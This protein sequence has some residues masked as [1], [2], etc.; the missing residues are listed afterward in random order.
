METPHTPL[1]WE[2]DG[3]SDI[4]FEEPMQTIFMVRGWGWLHKKYG[5]K[6]AIA[7]QRGNLKLVFKAVNNHD[8][9]VDLLSRAVGYVHD[10]VLSKQIEDLLNKIDNERK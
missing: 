1:P 4:Y 5:A 9:L 2:T 3:E 6:R 7:I 10:G 8:R